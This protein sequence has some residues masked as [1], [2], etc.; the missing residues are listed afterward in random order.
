MFSEARQQKNCVHLIHLGKQDYQ[1]VLLALCIRDHSSSPGEKD[2]CIQMSHSSQ[3]LPKIPWSKVYPS[4]PSP[5]TVLTCPGSVILLPVKTSITI[6]QLLRQ[7]SHSLAECLWLT[8]CNH[9]SIHSCGCW[10]ASD[11]LGYWPGTSIPCHAGYSTGQLI[12][13]TASFLQGRGSQR[14]EI[15]KTEA[16]TI[17]NHLR[18]FAIFY[19][20]A[21]RKSNSSEG[22]EHPEVGIN[23]SLRHPQVHPFVGQECFIPSLENSR[24]S[25]THI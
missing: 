11:P 4:L 18:S 1:I 12:N 24:E 2:N 13:R 19:M 22:P 14:K 16:K 17:Y 25:M 3:S 10:W 21:V 15:S 9:L 7:F 20:S 8:G 5:R 23:D 6:S